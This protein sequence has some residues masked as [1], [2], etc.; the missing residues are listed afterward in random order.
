MQKETSKEATFPKCSAKLGNLGRVFLGIQQGPI[1]F[2]MSCPHLVG[3]F[4]YVCGQ[5]PTRMVP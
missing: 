1:D 4:F 2:G 5:N 3:W